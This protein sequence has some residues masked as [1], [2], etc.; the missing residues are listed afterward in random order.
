MIYPLIMNVQHKQ[1]PIY[2]NLICYSDGRIFSKIKKRFLSGH[3]SMY[4]YVV[5]THCKKQHKVHRLILEAFIGF[6]SLPVDHKNMVKTDNRLDNLEY[7]THSEN[8]KRS[9]TLD[10]NRKSNGLIG[11]KN[12]NSKLSENEIKDILKAKIDGASTRELSI[13]YKISIGHV[14]SLFREYKK[15]LFLK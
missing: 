13:K 5:L 1:H 2:S 11:T 6:S 3:I 9:W 12:P 8:L 15:S 7:V 14:N 10:K 4:G